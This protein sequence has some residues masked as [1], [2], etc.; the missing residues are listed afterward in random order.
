[1][2]LKLFIWENC[3][4][5]FFVSYYKNLGGVLFKYGLSV[6]IKNYNVN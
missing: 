5:K 1:M 6:I 4:I 3:Y 2:L